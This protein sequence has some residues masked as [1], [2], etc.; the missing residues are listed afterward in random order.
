[1]DVKCDSEQ[2]G[3]RTHTHF[4]R[5]PTGPVQVRWIEFCPVPIQNSLLSVGPGGT[6]NLPHYVQVQIQNIMAPCR[7][8]SDSDSTLGL[9]VQV[10]SPSAN[11]RCDGPTGSMKRKR[12]HD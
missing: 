4:L 3:S 11:G 8:K 9:Q 6:P 7:L 10:E 12:R 5:S 1:M 2:E